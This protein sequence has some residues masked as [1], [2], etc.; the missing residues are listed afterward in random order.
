MYGQALSMF[1]MLQRA[2]MY[3]KEITSASTFDIEFD[4]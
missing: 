4:G 2:V 1:G 3:R